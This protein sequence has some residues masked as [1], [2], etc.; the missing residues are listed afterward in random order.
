MRGLL[1]LISFL[2]FYFF[3]LFFF[4]QMLLGVSCIFILAIIHL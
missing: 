4:F 2:F 1:F 3:I